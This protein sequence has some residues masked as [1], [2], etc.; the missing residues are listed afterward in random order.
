VRLTP[1]RDLDCGYLCGEHLAE[2]EQRATRTHV[3]LPE[4]PQTTGLPVVTY[5][6]LATAP[7]RVEPAG[8]WREYRGA[9]DYP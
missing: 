1:R 5:E 2:N 7:R 4:M 9:V 3:D 6:E 8:A